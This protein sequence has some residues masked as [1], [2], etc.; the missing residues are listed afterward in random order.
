MI[1]RSTDFLFRLSSIIILVSA[2]TAI[3][4]LFIDNPK[5]NTLEINRIDNADDIHVGGKIVVHTKG[6]VLVPTVPNSSERY[7]RNSYVFL[8]NDLS[9]IS[10]GCYERVRAYPVPPIAH[11]GAHT[12]QFCASFVLNPL[13]TVRR[14]NPPIPFMVLPALPDPEKGDKGDKGDRG[15]P[16]KDR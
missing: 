16:G 4:W 12:Y 5:F 2:T 7:I 15:P 6:C 13:K 1:K 3:Y 11:L 8:I 9:V 14:C 10:E